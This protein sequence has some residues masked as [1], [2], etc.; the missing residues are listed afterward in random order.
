M[1]GKRIL[2]IVGGGIAAYKACELI[3]LI[4]KAGG[5]V[6]CVLTSGGAQF[7]TADD[8]RRLVRAA[9]PHQ[10]V[11]PQ[12]RGRDGP[13][14]AVARGRPGRRL[15]GDG[16]SAGEDGGRHRRR[17]RHHPAARHRQEGARRAGDERAD[18][19]ARGDP[20][21]RRP[22]ARRRRRPSSSPTRARWRAANMARAAC[23]SPRRSSPRSRR[24]SAARARSPAAMS[25][26]TAGP[27]HEPIDPVRVLAN[28]SSGKQGFA[29]AGALAALGAR[30][31]L[32][33]GPVHLATPAGSTGSTSRPRAR[34]R[35]PST[36]RS[37]PTPRC[38]SP[39]SPTGGSI[40]PRPRSRRMRAGRPRF[41]W[42]RKSGHPRRTGPFAAPA[43]AV[44]R[45]RG[46]NRQCRRPRRA[47][48][49][50]KGV[51]LDPR[52]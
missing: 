32:V 30:V 3:R 18:V 17:S 26:V 38:W 6:R 45:L 2:L 23:P 25:I 15:P 1:R 41:R 5:S 44:G 37:P 35:R 48:R 21:Q 8:A 11:G 9:G 43:A 46:G 49:A 27:T 13:Y 4:R 47:K 51:R 52:Q 24:R 29:I 19:A 39:R 28:R 20:P 42:H 34:W 36:R 10:P 12:G 7:I 33:A 22:A 40:R 50:R 31:T 14:P 16:R